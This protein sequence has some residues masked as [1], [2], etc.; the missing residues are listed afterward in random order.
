MEPISRRGA[1][2]LGGLGLAGTVVGGAGLLWTSSSSGGI[3][4]APP[5]EELAEP[6]ELRSANGR[7]Q[8]R[9]DA[10]LGTVQVGGRSAS[11]LSFN[12]GIPGPTLRLKAGDRLGVTLHNGLDD[13]TNLHVHGLHVSPE[14]NGD[15]PFVMVEPGESFDYEYQLPANH[16][17][18]LYWYHPHHHGL[19]ADQIFGG[20][21]GA[22]IVEDPEPIGAARERVLVISDITLDGLGGIPAVSPMEQMM[23]REGEHMLANGQAN[24]RLNARTGERERWRIVN[25]CVSRYLRL[26]LDGQRMQLLGID[27]GRFGA[28]ETVEE[29]V[30]APGNRADLLVTMVDG[31]AVLETLPYD[32]GG[33]GGM[34]GGGE[35]PR[36]PTGRA[37]LATLTVAGEEVAAAPAVPAQPAPRDLRGTAVTARR[38]LT[39]A[40]GMGGMM[41][42]GG[43]MMSFTINGREFDGNRV[44]TT[45]E[46]GSVEEWTLRNTSPM[47][48]PVHLHVWPMQ[49]V[50]SDGRAPDTAIWQDVVN[51][52]A[53]G[54]IRVRIAF[55]DFAGR[56]V[57]HCHILDHEDNG[58]MGVIEV[59]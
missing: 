3:A 30:L 46:A 4:S 15:N 59:R 28:P 18:G 12:G 6:S 23:G 14:G 36:T 31:T 24:P 40:M 8:V 33:P 50:E 53:R 52:P 10:A 20:L 16:P 29:I 55:D 58:M 48:H 26:R 37:S 25:A 34:M 38:E 57:Y 2:T 32:R 39:F 56:S 49:I 27:S 17:P 1:L 5:G 45:V 35:Q 21:Y 13:P 43:S 7:L 51:V 9:L 44:D 42:G 41:G 47:D 11:A 54:Q 19:V 22:I